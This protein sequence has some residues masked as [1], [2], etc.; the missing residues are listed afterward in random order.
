MAAENKLVVP[1]SKPKPIRAPVIPTMVEQDKKKKH[2]R[3]DKH[4]KLPD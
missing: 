2:P 4:K 3:Q 1:A